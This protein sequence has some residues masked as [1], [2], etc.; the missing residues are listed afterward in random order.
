MASVKVSFVS[1]SVK[2]SCWTKSEWT[3]R[4]E[5]GKGYFWNFFRK[6]HKTK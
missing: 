2:L 4:V 6:D 5:V 3:C 1:G